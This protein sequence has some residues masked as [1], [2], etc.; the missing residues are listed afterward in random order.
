MSSLAPPAVRV[1]V[2]DP[3]Q[4]SAARR[5][6]LALAESAGLAEA[7]RDHL[8]LVVTE[9]ATNLV[10]HAAGGECVFRSLAANDTERGGIEI[11]CIDRG[12]GMAN[13][14]ACMRDGYSTAGSPGGGLGAMR[15][16]STS[17]DVHSAPGQGTV[18][19]LELRDAGAAART[20]RALRIGAV[21]VAC[22]GEVECGDGWATDT[23][24]P[25][26][27]L[28][29]DGL[30]HGHFA[31]QASQAAIAAF[32]ESASDDPE[33]L[34]LTLD[35]ALRPTRGAAAAVVRVDRGRGRVTYCGVGNTVGV[36]LH[37]D[38]VQRMVSQPGTLGTGVRRA[39]PFEYDWTPGS[40][41]V[42][43]TDGVSSRWPVDKYAGV[44]ARHPSLLAALLYR[45]FGRDADDATVV[46]ARE[47]A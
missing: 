18:I 24:A 19:V 8:A 9:A 11:V 32:Q 33:R 10:K 45:D 23:G 12:P 28:L 6:A 36:L 42:L 4:V 5:A 47:A 21:A 20:G 22:R 40:T 25:D 35:D 44:L 1:S 3:S 39:R 17:F 38:R 7:T 30:G 41:L 13:V 27:L 29:V 15:R 46:V 34:V 26:T 14:A 43:H 31:A 2:Q 37:A 16:L